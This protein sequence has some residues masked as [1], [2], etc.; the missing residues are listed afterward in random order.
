VIDLRDPSDESF[1]RLW[2]A[3]LA[4]GLDP[5]NVFDWDGTRSPFPGMVS[6]EEEDAPVFFGRET[7]IQV[8]MDLLNRLR[9]FN[10]AHLAVILGSSGSGKSSLVRAGLLPRLRRDAGN[11]V[12]GQSIRPRKDAFKAAA[13]WSATAHDAGG[14][15][16]GD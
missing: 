16:V 4:A 7:Q 11:L 8:G 10:E 13:G 1:Q 9:R 2:R 3:L 15:F 14:G 6:F 12:A 5:A